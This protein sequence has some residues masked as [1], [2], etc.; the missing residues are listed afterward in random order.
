MRC[1]HSTRIAVFA[2]HS[3]PARLEG[4]PFTKCVTCFEERDW[5]G[6]ITLP[7]GA[8][9]ERPVFWNQYAKTIY[10]K[11]VTLS[12]AVAVQLDRVSVEQQ[13][14]LELG[15]TVSEVIDRGST[16]SPLPIPF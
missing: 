5:T 6:T 16:T 2:H 8:Y 9:T 3:N 14:R 11:P 10:G 7:A 12:E 4:Y 15:G 1:D 13:N